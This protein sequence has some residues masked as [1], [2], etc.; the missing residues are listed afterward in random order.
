MTFYNLPKQHHKNIKSSN[1]IE[2][3]H[4]EFKR[5]TFVVRIFPN[6]ES[7]LRLIRAIAVEM[8]ESWIERSRY[9]NMDFYRE[10]K[11]K[12]LKMKTKAA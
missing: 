6:K 9:I 7:C 8:Q 11:K 3:L 5:R 10:L 1:V 4:E 12:N 2:R